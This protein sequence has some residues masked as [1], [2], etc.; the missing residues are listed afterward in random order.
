MVQIPMGLPSLIPC[1]FLQNETTECCRVTDNLLAGVVTSRDPL[2]SNEAVL[3]CSMFY[4]R[5]TRLQNIAVL[6]TVLAAVATC[7]DPL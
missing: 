3:T 5:M 1:F 2:Y 7:R 4:Y 6:L